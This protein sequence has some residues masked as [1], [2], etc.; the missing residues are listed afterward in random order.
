MSKS[1][2][3]V[4][5]NEFARIRGVG[6]SYISKLK[7]QGRLVLVRQGGKDLI[8][9]EASIKSLGETADPGRSRGGAGVDPDTSPKTYTDAKTHN[10]VLRGQLYQLELSTKSGRLVDIRDVEQEYSRRLQRLRDALLSI[11]ARLT[12]MLAAENR[13]GEIFRMIDV[14]I[15]QVLAG[16][17][18]EVES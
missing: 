3:L 4:N 13:D 5:A 12:P 2:N 17:G 14:E 16:A 9:V 8:D 6:A 15:R 11:P 7:R 10:E 18:Q 1:S